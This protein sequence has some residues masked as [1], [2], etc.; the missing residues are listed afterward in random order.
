MV[1]IT[2]EV[3]CG[4]RE[5]EEDEDEEDKASCTVV[6]YEVSNW[7]TLMGLELDDMVTFVV[8]AD[9]DITVCGDN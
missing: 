9:A 2:N 7:D 6:S 8:I 4:N 3:D 1:E 5:L